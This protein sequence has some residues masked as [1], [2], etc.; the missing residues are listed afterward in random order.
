M[1]P[2]TS[3]HPSGPQSMAWHGISAHGDTCWQSARSGSGYQRAAASG[4]RLVWKRGTLISK[5]W[6]PSRRAKPWRSCPGL[7]RAR[8]MLERETE[9]SALPTARCCITLRASSCSN[10]PMGALSCS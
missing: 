6:Q 10:P 1:C 3:P 7:R 8:E 9:I 2:E 5:A 4:R